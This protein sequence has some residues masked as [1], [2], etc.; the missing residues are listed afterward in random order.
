MGRRIGKKAL[1]EP[2]HQRGG[3]TR[4]IPFCLS[5][6]LLV[7]LIVVS[8]VWERVVTVGLTIRLGELRVEFNSLENDLNSLKS[9]LS[10]LSSQDRLES[11]A[12]TMGMG[13]P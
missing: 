11:L 6:F 3:L 12:K 10:S 1:R 9:Q 7:L 5:L 13:Y 2:E 8:H 4:S